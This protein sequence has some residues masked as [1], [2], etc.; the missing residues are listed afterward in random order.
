MKRT[1]AAGAFVAFVA[2][3]AERRRVKPAAAPDGGKS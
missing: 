2:A 3:G 1:V